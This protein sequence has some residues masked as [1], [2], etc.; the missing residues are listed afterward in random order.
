VTRWDYDAESAGFVAAATHTIEP[1][2]PPL[3]LARAA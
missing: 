2:A 1:P 3:V